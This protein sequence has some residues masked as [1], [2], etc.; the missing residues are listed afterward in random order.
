M[1]PFEWGLPAV[2][3]LCFYILHDWRY[4]DFHTG[5]FADFEHFKIHHFT[6]FK[7]V[8][9]ILWSLSKE[10]GFQKQLKPSPF[11]TKF[12]KYE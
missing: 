1:E 6:K 5:H 10:L 7:Q 11:D 12:K 3:I 2:Q 9:V 4:I 8:T